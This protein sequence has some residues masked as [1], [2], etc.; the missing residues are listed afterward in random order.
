MFYIHK[1]GWIEIVDGGGGEN[2]PNNFLRNLKNSEP[3]VCE[4]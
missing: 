3:P 2:S 1:N 4:L